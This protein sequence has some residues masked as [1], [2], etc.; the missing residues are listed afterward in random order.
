MD[1]LIFITSISPAESCVEKQKRAI[2]SWKKLG[3]KSYSVNC[4]QEINKL[5]SIYS[6][7][8]FIEASET[9][10]KLY[11]KPY[12]FINDLLDKGK[13]L[14]NHLMCIINADIILEDNKE[15]FIQFCELC[16]NNLVFAARYN[17]S[18]TLEDAVKEPWGLDIFLFPKK[19]VDIFKKKDYAMGQ[20]F[21]DLWFPCVFVANKIPITFYDKSLFYHKIHPFDW[22]LET[23]KVLEKVFNEE[24]NT[25]DI[26][27]MDKYWNTIKTATIIK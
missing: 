3:I 9:A 23:W 22:T 14:T 17:F 6:D 16:N 15:K 2:A 4:K 27:A 12:I 8:I 1:D 11:T 25:W 21:W 18:N 19:Y 10:E 20:P 26:N 24:F 5:S 13:S 7:I